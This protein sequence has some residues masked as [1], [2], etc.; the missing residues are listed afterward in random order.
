[1]KEKRKNDEVKDLRKKEIVDGSNK[2]EDGRKLGRKEENEEKIRRKK[3][4]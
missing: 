3:R 4:E 1:M 2:R